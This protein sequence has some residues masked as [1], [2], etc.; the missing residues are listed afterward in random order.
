MSAN[1]VRTKP[2][3]NRRG[4]S[5]IFMAIYLALLLTT[6]GASLVSAQQ[7][8]HSTTVE[9]LKLEQVRQQEA[10]FLQIDSIT[11]MGDYIDTIS[12]NN[13]GS[14]V[15]KIKGIYI[16][17]V[18]ILDP[19]TIQNTYVR[20]QSC[21]TIKLLGNANVPFSVN[22]Y[23]PI[24]ITTERGTKY[25]EIIANLFPK[26]VQG[27]QIDFAYGPL[28]LVFEDFHWTTFKNNFDMAYLNE[29]SWIEG[30]SVPSNRVGIWRVRIQNIDNRDIHLNKQSCLTLVSNEGGARY[31]YYIDTLNSDLTLRQGEPAR[32][33][34]FTWKQ[35]DPTDRRSNNAESTPQSSGPNGARSCITFL[36]FAGKIDQKPLGETIPFEAVLVS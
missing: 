6:L 28:K 21:I 10:L 20:P 1:L 11:V 32:F 19:A 29:A 12:I 34:Y 4:L 27:F 15:E 35:P 9:R 26:I 18:L 22:K 31:T 25:T 13:T 7:I 36:V 16:N 17:S 30:W 24:T 3:R 14:I 23:C 5:S 33:V 8:S 2:P